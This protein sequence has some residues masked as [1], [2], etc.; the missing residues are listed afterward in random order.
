MAEGERRDEDMNHPHARELDY[1]FRET[2]NT[3]IY[4]GR[5]LL[6]YIIT[7]IILKKNSR[8]IPSIKDITNILYDSHGTQ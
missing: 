1:P 6:Y 7:P 2:K 4:I 8:Q 3:E 5:I